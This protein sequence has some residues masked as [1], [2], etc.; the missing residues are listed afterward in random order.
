MACSYGYLPITVASPDSSHCA[1]EST[2]NEL[3]IHLF[4]LPHPPAGEVAEILATGHVGWAVTANLA[5]LNTPLRF[6]TRF[7]RT[8]G[9]EDID[10]CLRL[11]HP[12]GARA[13]PGKGDEQHAELMRWRVNKRRGL[14]TAGASAAGSRLT[15]EAGPTPDDNLLRTWSAC[16]A[17]PGA[18][19]HAPLYATTTT[20]PSSPHQHASCSSTDRRG[21]VAVPQVG[22]VTRRAL[23][24]TTCC[25][26]NVILPL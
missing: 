26:L 14:S 11:W 21:L 9:G 5:A 4:A 16:P 12:P 8:G 1:Q 18:A 25:M 3:N 24:H 23:G 10:W 6:D 13:E 19:T 22:E 17:G 2:I 20:T 15:A 7:P